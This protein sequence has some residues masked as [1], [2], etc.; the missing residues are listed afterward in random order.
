MLQSLGKFSVTGVLI[1]MSF[2]IITAITGFTKKV[3]GQL[4]DYDSV[5]TMDY[6]HVHGFPS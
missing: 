4:L 2:I 5:F 3:Q 1:C 6:T